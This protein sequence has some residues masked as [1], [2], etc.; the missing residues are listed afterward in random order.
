ME[1]VYCGEKLLDSPLDEILFEPATFYENGIE[2][3][4]AHLTNLEN[5]HEV[6][7][8]GASDVERVEQLPDVIAPGM[9]AR[10]DFSK[11]L[12]EGQLALPN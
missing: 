5:K 12:I 11:A 3:A 10:Q 7:A 9:V 6:F 2:I 8:V 1:E 4:E